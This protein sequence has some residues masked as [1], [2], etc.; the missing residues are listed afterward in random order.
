MAKRNEAEGTKGAVAEQKLQDTALNMIGVAAKLPVVRVDRD[1]FL[2]QQFADSPHL[3][4]ILEHGPQSV[5]T[6]ESLRE[7]SKKVVKSN[8]TKTAS[9][10][11]VAGLPANPA[12]MIPAGGADVVQYFGFAIRMAQQIAYLF[13]EDDLF[14]D[15]GEISEDAKI[16]VIALLGGMFGAS[17][18]AVLI[19]QTSKSLG[20]NLGAKIAANALTK[21]AWYPLLKKSLALIGQNITKQT[22]GKTVAKAVPVLGGVVSAGLTFVAFR[23]MGHRL[24]EVFIRNLN[25]EFDPA[26]LELNEDFAATLVDGEVVGEVVFEDE[27]LESEAPAP[28]RDKD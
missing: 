25:G 1:Q 11:F 4:H 8:T 7:K 2:R 24:T 26:E 9:V 21:T 13:G 19:S 15:S 28:E 14:G 16:R 20:A 5:Y 17:G 22:V 10:S 3:D 12:M 6:P 23:P 27:V 18:A